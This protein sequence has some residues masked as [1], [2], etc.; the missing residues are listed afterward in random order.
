MDSKPIGLLVA[1]SVLKWMDKKAVH[2]FTTMHE[3]V[4]VKVE[5][6]DREIGRKITKPLYCT[7]QQKYESSGSTRYA[8]QFLEMSTEN[9]EMVQ[10]IIFSF[11]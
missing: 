7:I 8:K 5:K 1:Y 4:I 2:M 11:I 9:S 10:G 3:S 6:N